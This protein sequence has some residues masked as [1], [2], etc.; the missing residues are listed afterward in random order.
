MRSRKSTAALDTLSNASGDSGRGSLVDSIQNSSSTSQD[1]WQCT[2]CTY[3]NLYSLYSC[4]ICG[5]KKPSSRVARS[6]A[7][8]GSRS[9]QESTSPSPVSS[10][11]I[12]GSLDSGSIHSS[13]PSCPSP[14]ISSR[15]ASPNTMLQNATRKRKRTGRLKISDMVDLKV[16]TTSEITI[17]EKTVVITDFKLKQIVLDQNQQYAMDRLNNSGSGD[18]NNSSVFIKE[19]SNQSSLDLESSNSVSGSTTSAISPFAS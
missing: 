7:V 15:S 8:G 6:S 19:E 12:S 11:L 3:T 2:T 14:A 4:E 18:L 17:G 16:F 13:D 9:S 5:G 10:L 1:T